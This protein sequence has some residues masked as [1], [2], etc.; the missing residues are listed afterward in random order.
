[1][2]YFLLLLSVI[3]TLGAT[4]GMVFYETPFLTIT[5]VIAALWFWIVTAGTLHATIIQLEEH[6]QGLQ[7]KVEELEKHYDDKK[8]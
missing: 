6:L 4:T 3:L 7:K 1:M 2:V 5:L 8:D